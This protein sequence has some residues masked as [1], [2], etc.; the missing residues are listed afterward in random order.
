MIGEEVFLGTGD[1][2][3]F[4]GSVGERGERGESNDEEDWKGTESWAVGKERKRGGGLFRV[5]SLSLASSCWSCSSLKWNMAFFWEGLR[6]GTEPRETK[7][8]GPW[9]GSVGN[10]R[11][12]SWPCQYPLAGAWSRLLNGTTALGGRVRVRGQVQQRS[13]LS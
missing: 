2:M 8:P 7:A 4:L 12:A 1:L 3:T 13:S 9:D 5:E 10:D 6:L 11:T